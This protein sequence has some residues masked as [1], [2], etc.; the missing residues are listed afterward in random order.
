MTEIEGKK[1]NILSLFNLWTNLVVVPIRY[2]HKKIPK[3][4][5]KHSLGSQWLIESQRKRITRNHPTNCWLN[6][7]DTNAVRTE[8]VTWWA[9][10]VQ[11]CTLEPSISLSTNQTH[12]GFMASQGCWNLKHQSCSLPLPDHSSNPKAK[13]YEWFERYLLLHSFAL[14]IIIIITT[15]MMHSIWH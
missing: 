6:L 15:S 2:S 11:K 8:I 1:L 10:T 9:G 4:L 12:T 7:I 3:F 13:S 5:S 14:L